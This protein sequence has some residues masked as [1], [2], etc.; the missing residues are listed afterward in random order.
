MTRKNNQFKCYT[1]KRI[2]EIGPF[3]PLYDTHLIEIYMQQVIALLHKDPYLHRA[4]NKGESRRLKIIS[5]YRHV[6]ENQYVPRINLM[7]RWLAN[8][9]FTMEQYVRVFLLNKVLVICLDEEYLRGDILPEFQE[10]YQMSYEV[11]PDE[12]DDDRAYK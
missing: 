8:A 4:G 10:K 2:E 12:L 3:P 5:Q 11:S 7:G 9:G 6:E 1:E